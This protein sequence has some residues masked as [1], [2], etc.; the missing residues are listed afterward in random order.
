MKIIPEGHGQTDGQTTYCGIIALCRA[1]CGKNM[2]NKW[3][4]S[5]RQNTTPDLY[6]HET[7][8]LSICILNWQQS[9]V[10]HCTNCTAWLNRTQVCTKTKNNDPALFQLHFTAHQAILLLWC[11]STRRKENV[12]N[13]GA[14]A[15]EAVNNVSVTTADGT[16]QWPHATDVFMLHM[17]TSIHQTLN[18][19]ASHVFSVACIYD[20][21]MQ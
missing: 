1:L 17:G 21:T 3:I 5:F 20:K 10:I 11:I 19:N 2:K 18:L 15:Q 4:W 7:F 9:T 14:F 13:F 8:G 12:T 6:S 16:V